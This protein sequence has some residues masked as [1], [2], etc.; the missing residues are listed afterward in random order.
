[1]SEEKIIIKRKK[2]F[3]F[4]VLFE[5]L[6][7]II[8]VFLI[9][10][11]FIAKFRIGTVFNFSTSTREETV[12]QQMYDLTGNIGELL[13]QIGNHFDFLIIVLISLLAILSLTCILKFHNIERKLIENQELIL[14]ILDKTKAMAK[15]ENSLVQDT[16]NTPNKCPNCG[17]EYN[18][19]DKFCGSCGA[20]LN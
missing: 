11:G 10:I 7:F 16:Q 15:D 12:F 18:L 14:E 1:M 9:I 13:E 20:K 8:L 3:E 4:P 2:S 6:G 19:G 17:K 5:I